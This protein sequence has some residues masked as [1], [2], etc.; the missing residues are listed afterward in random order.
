MTAESDEGREYYLCRLRFGRRDRYVI[1]F[2]DKI[3]GFVR[4]DDG[5]LLTAASPDAVA[6]AAAAMGLTLRPEAP[7][8]YEF[9]ALEEWCRSPEVE[10][11]DC[12]AFLNA[13]NFFDDLADLHGRPNSA[14]AKLSRSADTTYDMLFDGCNLPS[15]TTPGEEYEPSW[16]SWE[17]SQMCA[18]FEAG[19]EILRRELGDGSRAPEPPSR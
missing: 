8:V 12:N 15:V 14:F 17:L 10:G 19:L 4:R 2:T 9:D 16:S 7:A 13:W 11:V 1:W 18:V 3:D 5:R 6:A